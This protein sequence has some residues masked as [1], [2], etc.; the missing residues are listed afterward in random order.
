VLRSHLDV[1]ARQYAVLLKRAFRLGSVVCFGLALCGN[2]MPT[3]SW[4]ITAPFACVLVT[5]KEIQWLSPVGPLL[6]VGSQTKIGP[7]FGTQRRTV[8]GPLR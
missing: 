6:A 3:V 5:H 7:Q 4:T 1:S 8:C 2:G